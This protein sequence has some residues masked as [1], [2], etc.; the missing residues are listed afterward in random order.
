MPQAD[1][2]AQR[3]YY[4]DT[5]ERYDAMH[6]AEGDEHYVALDWLS[7]LIRQHDIRSVLDI[8]SG[9][10]RGILYLKQRHPIH[11][12]GIE[13]VAALRDQG[14]AK[15]L[16]V[17]ELIDGNALKLAFPD[18]AF[19]LVCAFGVLHHIKDHRRAVAEM[20]RVARTGVFLSDS[21]NFGQGSPH[22]R[23]LKR[24]VAALGLWRLADLAMTRGKGYHYS[25]G[26]GVFYSYSLF[27]DLPVLRGKFPK[28]SFM[29]T[30]P[31]VGPDLY[32]HASHVAVFAGA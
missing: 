26:D 32:R 25:P 17:D 2:E 30:K 8:G 23:R 24:T 19:D 15:G 14:H 28:L 13:P 1:V 9:T 31:A 5:A 10:G 21:N 4:A 3:A 12:V 20:C 22:K 16:S 11:Y 29:N 27:D 6:V 18:D 7:D